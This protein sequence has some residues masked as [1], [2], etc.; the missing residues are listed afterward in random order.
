MYL[1]TTMKG[2]WENKSSRGHARPNR[3]NYCEMKERKEG[4]TT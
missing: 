3:M 1:K 2:W 4:T